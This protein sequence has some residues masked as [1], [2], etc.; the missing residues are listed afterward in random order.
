M[1]NTTGYSFGDVVL[2]PFPFTD[3]STAK[4]RPAVVVSSVVY[5]AERPDLNILAVTSQPSARSGLA[6]AGV[7][8][9]KRAGL[10]KPSV[11]KPV[12]TTIDRHLV[13]RKLGALSDRDR[14]ALAGLLRSMLGE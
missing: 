1:P 2:V 9:W 4:Q 14:T 8:D 12:V 6:E 10:L 5:N 11:F 7:R 3:Q 13:L